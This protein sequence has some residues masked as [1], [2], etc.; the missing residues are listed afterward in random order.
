MDQE[1]TNTQDTDLGMDMRNH[2]ASTTHTKHWFLIRRTALPRAEALASQHGV[3]L[4][5]VEPS[6]ESWAGTIAEKFEIPG[7]SRLPYDRFPKWVREW[8]HEFCQ[9]HL[10]IWVTSP[11]T[12]WSVVGVAKREDPQSLPTFHSI[13]GKVGYWSVERMDSVN[14]SRC[15]E[16]GVRHSRKQ[17]IVIQKGEEY[18]QIGGSCT[19]HLDLG[20]KMKDLLKGF[21]SF[22]GGVEEDAGMGACFYGKMSLPWGLTLVLVKAAITLK[23]Y[24]SGYYALLSNQM[25][26]REWVDYILSERGDQGLTKD[27]LFLEYRRLL[28]EGSYTEAVF[29]LETG[30]ENVLEEM[31][32]ED[33]EFYRNCDAAYRNRSPRGLGFLCFLV[34]KAIG[35]VRPE[36][37]KKP[38]PKPLPGID[39]AQKQGWEA[40]LVASGLTDPELR[41]VYKL[42]ADAKP[43]VLKKAVARSLP[44]VW[45][46]TTRASWESEYGQQ[47]LLVLTR[48]SDGA[49]VRWVT[50]SLPY[51]PGRGKETAGYR[52]GDK[53]L[54]LGCSVG[55]D[56]GRHPKYGEEGTKISR[57][58]L[59]EI[60]G[61]V[62]E[63]EDSPEC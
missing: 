13:G 35:W 58:T 22:K 33:G 37:V 26:T 21:E 18:R 57:V 16:C 56:R 36:K 1:T 32:K 19:R 52:K 49:R 39:R 3:A 47:D 27:P 60:P 44:G 50:G 29:E 20:K 54:I 17:V 42:P 59:G 23:G 48:E 38:E 10:E 11:K 4:E 61:K 63:T 6:E 46:V 40:V 9:E 14:F 55:E 34:S 43:G 8:A 5:V 45:E 2:K 24:I 51:R 12:E 30:I 28:E 41:E 53:F 25:S 15:D 62:E 7:W 31:G